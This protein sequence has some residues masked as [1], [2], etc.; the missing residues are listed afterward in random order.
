MEIKEL[1]GAGRYSRFVLYYLAI[2]TTFATQ[3]AVFCCCCATVDHDFPF[4]L[5][6]ST[7][8]NLY[9][10]CWFLSANFVFHVSHDI[11]VHAKT[12]A[13]Y[14]AHIK[15]AGLRTTR[16]NGQPLIESQGR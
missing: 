13:D 2:L 15:P 1:S 16:S 9:V 8:Y 5:L 7:W 12:L 6:F 14:T 3:T 4:A 11:Q 10:F